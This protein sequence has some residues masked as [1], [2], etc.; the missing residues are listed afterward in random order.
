[1][2]RRQRSKRRK[3]RWRA[4]NAPVIARFY[5]VAVTDEDTIHL[6]SDGKPVKMEHAR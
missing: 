3:Q 2:T 6:V 5:I 4:R 1:M